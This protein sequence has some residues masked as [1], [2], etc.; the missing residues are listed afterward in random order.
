M[1]SFV[2]Y[3][4]LGFFH[5]L[6]LEAYDHL[7]FILAL[8]APYSMKEWKK[9]LVLITAFTLGHCTTLVL[10]TFQLV[11]FSTPIIE[12]LIPLTIFITALTNLGQNNQPLSSLFRLRWKSYLLTL[13]FGLIHGLGFSNFLRSLLGKEADIFTALLAFNIGIEIGQIVIIVL[14]FALLLGINL[15][16]PII[17][18][19]QN[20]FISGA[21]AGIALVLI[22]QTKFW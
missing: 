5:I 3:L 14:L 15:F 11:V 22:L 4:E 1:E 2:S 17:Q 19:D 18:R 8:C 12:F 10:A 20:L 6:N 16:F 7:V 21:A 9:L 13:F